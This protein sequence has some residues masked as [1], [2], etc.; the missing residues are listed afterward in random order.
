MSDRKRPCPKEQDIDADCPFTIVYKANPPRAE[1]K[2]EKE[3]NGKTCTRRD[4]HDSKHFQLQTFD[5]PRTSAFKAMDVY[6]VVQPS[7]R[8]LGMTRYKNFRNGFTCTTGDF[9]VVAN[10]QSIKRQCTENHVQDGNSKLHDDHWIAQVLE[11]RALDTFNIYA[12]VSWMYRPHDIPPGTLRGR[13]IIEGRQPYHG[14]RE[15][16]MSNHMDIIDVM[17]IKETTDVRRWIGSDDEEIKDAFYYRQAYNC[18]SR[19]LSPVPRT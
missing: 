18:R 8:W 5:F 14:P 17:S 9:V 1:E 16:I 10:E 11:I 2:R 6:Y 15:L 13:T 7:N 3:K 19:V 12:R 4:R